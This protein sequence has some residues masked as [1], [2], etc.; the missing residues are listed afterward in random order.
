M[1][2]AASIPWPDLQSRVGRGDGEDDAK[3]NAPEDRAQREFRLSGLCRHDGRVGFA[4]FQR[5]VGVFWKE[6]RINL[7][8]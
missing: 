1:G 7:S 8:H 4:R 5:P 3:H 6:L 2:M